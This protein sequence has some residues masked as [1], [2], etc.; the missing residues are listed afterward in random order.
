M[1]SPR[2]H[3]TVGVRGVSER[4]HPAIGCQTGHALSGIRATQ[5]IQDYI[6]PSAAGSIQHGRGKGA[7]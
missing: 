1:K 5:R 4:H 2:I 6:R 3:L 7:V